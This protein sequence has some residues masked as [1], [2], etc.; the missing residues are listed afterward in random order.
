MKTL[1]E[2]QTDL[3]RSARVAQTDNWDPWFGPEPPTGAAQA[4][5]RERWSAFYLARWPQVETAAA[6]LADQ[7]SQ[8]LLYQLILYRILGHGHIRLPLN[9]PAY[10]D[11]RRTVEQHIVA[12]AAGQSWHIALD[13]FHV[14]G[15]NYLGYTGAMLVLHFLHQYSFERDGM[16]IAP[17]PGDVVL[18]AGAFVGDTALVFA[19]AVG[20]GGRVFAFEFVPTNLALFEANMATNADLAARVTLIPHALDRRSGATLSYVDRGP[21][22]T[23]VRDPAQATGS[24]ETRSI[25][26]FVARQGLDRVDFIKMDVEGAEPDVLIG[27]TETIRRFR[28]KLAISAYHQGDHLFELPVLIRKLLPDYRLY[29]DH[30]TIREQETV[31]YAI[32]DDRTA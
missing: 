32:P 18:D 21:A 17:E 13:R 23:S 29:L 3:M 10:W 11:L 30:H 25:D 7:A 12:R 22:S 5:H 16:R 4:P 9:T 15:L 2:L 14:D 28:P 26:D 27:A 6:V 8:D 1:H 20:P 31:L 24:I 19:Q